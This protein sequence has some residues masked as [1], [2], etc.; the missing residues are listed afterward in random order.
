MP[1]ALPTPEE[2]A[3]NSASDSDFDASL[4]PSSGDES[5][6]SDAAKKD[7]KRKTDADGDVDMASGDE[8]IVAQ[9]RKKRRRKGKGKGKEEAGDGT[10]EVGV[11]GEDE[12]EG[13]VGIRVR[14]RSGR[15][16][17]DESRKA[18]PKSSGTTIDIDSVWA[19]LNNP[20]VSRPVTDPQKATD[21]ISNAEN[22][23]PSSEAVSKATL[24]PSL[25]VS[26]PEPTITIPH[27]YTFAGQ[28]H[29]STKIVP[30]SSK[31]AQAYL[32]S[33]DKDS[34]A[35][36]GPVLRRPL[37][38]K[39]LLDPNPQ[40]LIKGVARSPR[41]DLPTSIGGQGTKHLNAATKAKVWEVG[42]KKE[43]KLNT[44]EKS[45]LDWEAEVERQGLRE[46]LEKAEKSGGSY[47]GRMEFL[48]RGDQMRE[49]EAKKAR[50]KEM[51]IAG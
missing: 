7:R 47:L 33:K 10:G 19:R 4:S 51:G 42:K 6:A 35:T 49:E 17:G 46:E 27:T 40:C 13:G 1:P 20:Q 43:V 15:G 23:P 11:E 14:L 34:T 38:R 2:D 24:L 3:Y 5:E 32:A 25:Q 48:G 12:E 36:T 39:G 41:S 30:A 37:A 16:G 22:I 45:K 9:G 21:T 44:V 18:L 8:G 28:K 31:E 50:L 29:T 26:S